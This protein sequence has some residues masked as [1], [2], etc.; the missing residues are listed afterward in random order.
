V[1]PLFVLMGQ[2]AYRAGTTE[3]LYQAAY[4]WVGRMPGGLACTTVA[5]SAGFSAICGSNSATTA[6]HG[7]HRHAGNAPLRLRP[8]AVQRRHR[9]GAARSAW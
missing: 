8:G 5:A 9:G 2:F 4:T 1:I 7:H 6:N 3:R